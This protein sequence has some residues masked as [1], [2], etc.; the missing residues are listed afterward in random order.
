MYVFSNLEKSGHYLFF[1][2]DR[3]VHAH[4]RGGGW[5][6]DV[7]P[8][9]ETREWRDGCRLISRN[10]LVSNSSDPLTLNPLDPEVE[11]AILELEKAIEIVKKAGYQICKII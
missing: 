8:V 4:W 2:G 6:V 9:G 1:I 7:G 10:S 3:I 11:N 5:D